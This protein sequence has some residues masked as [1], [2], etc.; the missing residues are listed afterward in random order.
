MWDPEH[1]K[2]SKLLVLGFVAERWYI[3]QYGVDVDGTNAYNMVLG[4]FGH[5]STREA[6][7][8][9][10]RGVGDRWRRSKCDKFDNVELECWRLRQPWKCR[11]PF[12][13]VGAPSH[14]RQTKNT[15]LNSVTRSPYTKEKLDN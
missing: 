4:T 6:V 5:V 2:F 7:C 10:D 11:V 8:A 3:R 1:S 13:R 15:T 9:N 14:V 12:Q